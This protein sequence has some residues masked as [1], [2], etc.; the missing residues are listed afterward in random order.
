[1][2]L[3][4]DAILS[5]RSHPHDSLLRLLT[6]SGLPAKSL[7]YDY[8]TDSENCGFTMNIF[9]QVV[10]DLFIFGGIGLKS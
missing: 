2:T 3:Q 6:I 8:Q 5:C 9:T 7:N 10:T 1:M 4:F